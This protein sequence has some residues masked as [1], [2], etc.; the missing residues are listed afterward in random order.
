M[1]WKSF[2]D[3]LALILGVSIFGVLSALTWVGKIPAESLLAMSGPLLTL[4]VQFYF[5]KT[6]DKGNGS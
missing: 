3:R 5:R 6:P 2:N 4:I 1:G